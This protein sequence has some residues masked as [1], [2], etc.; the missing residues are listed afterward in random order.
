MFNESASEELM[1]G[2]GRGGGKV[3]SYLLLLC[4]VPVCA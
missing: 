2:V 1:V 4:L 3:L